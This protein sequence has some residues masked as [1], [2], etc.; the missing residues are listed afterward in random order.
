MTAY[1]RG[2]PPV[3]CSEGGIKDFT[4]FGRKKHGA[5]GAPLSHP[6]CLFGANVTLVDMKRKF[7]GVYPP[8]LATF[9]TTNSPS[10]SCATESKA[11]AISM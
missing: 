9:L 1:V 10:A 11:L 7:A 5:I 4:N 2:G 6:I 8:C 3:Y